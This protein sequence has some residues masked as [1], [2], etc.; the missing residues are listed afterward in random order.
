MSTIVGG[1]V[2][3]LVGGKFANGAVGSALSSLLE[4]A[5]LDS[6]KELVVGSGEGRGA[7]PS[8][9]DL[10]IEAK[11]FGSANEAAHAFGEKYGPLGLDGPREYNTGIIQLGDEEFG[12]VKPL[13][14][15]LGSKTVSVGA[16]DAALQA[17][18]GDAYISLAHTHFDSNLIFSSYDVQVAQILPLYLHN[19]SGQTLLLNSDIIRRTIRGSS[20]KG[21]NALRQYLNSNQGMQGECVYG[22]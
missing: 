19:R 7:S 21:P 10:S 20:Y 18:Y 6:S 1:T 8:F 11:G 5:Q 16:Y 13:A 3:K 9:A 4:I 14:G 17:R 22:C 12:Y 2:S 15:E